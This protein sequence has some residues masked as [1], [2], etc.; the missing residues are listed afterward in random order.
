MK[1]LL[2]L[3]IPLYKYLINNARLQKIEKLHK[4]FQ[5]IVFEKNNNKVFETKSEVLELFKIAKINDVYIQISENLGYGYFSN[6]VVSVLNN[7]PSNEI[8]FFQHQNIM[9]IEAIGVFKKRKKEAYSIFY[10]LDFLIFLPQKV[11]EYLNFPLNSVFIKILNF[12][13]WV[14]S[15][16]LTLAITLFHEEIKN[17]ILSI[18]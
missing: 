11:L 2:I 5:T 15:T 3:S 10:W 6:G 14:F 9:F 13:F 4:I 17:Y 16:L 7:Y 18:L 8:N 1:F 12:I